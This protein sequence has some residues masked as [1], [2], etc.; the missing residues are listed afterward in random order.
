MPIKKIWQNLKFNVLPKVEEMEDEK[1]TWE[2][3]V[4]MML[5]AGRPLVLM[6]EGD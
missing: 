3:Q 4:M 2:D 5:Y 1:S 6:W